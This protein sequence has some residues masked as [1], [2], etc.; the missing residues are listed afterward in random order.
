[1]LQSRVL[2][3]PWRP[4]RIR[5]H[6]LLPTLRRGAVQLPCEVRGMHLS[7]LL[8]QV[9]CRYTAEGGGPSLRGWQVEAARQSVEGNLDLSC[10]LHFDAPLPQVLD[11]P[12]G[13]HYAPAAGFQ[14]LLQ[15]GSPSF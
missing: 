5:V 4:L 13:S 9:G 3:G 1:M 12:G 15:G 10:A 11:Q 6:Q 7:L 2:P 14:Q 8:G